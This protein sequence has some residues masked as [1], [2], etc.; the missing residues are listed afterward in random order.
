MSSPLR[1]AMCV[2]LVALLSAVSAAAE[3]EPSAAELVA[4]AGRG[5]FMQF[6]EAGLRTARLRVAEDDGGR[7]WWQGLKSRAD[8]FLTEPTEVPDCEGAS[9]HYVYF[10]TNCA[11]TLKA[12]SPRRHVCPKC[13]A[14]HS[15]VQYDR[16]YASSRHGRAQDVVETLGLAFA[17]TGQ[18]AYG[19]KAKAYLLGYAERYGSYELHNNEGWGAVDEKGRRRPHLARAHAQP[20]DE[21]VWLIALLRGFDAT[22]TLFSD[23]ERQMVSDRL[24]R[25]A[26][27]VVRDDNFGIQNHECWH[28]SAYG[29]AGLALGD[30]TLVT[31]AIDGRTG[32]KQQLARGVLP[33]G[34]W[35]EG[36]PGYHLYALN[37]LR[38]MVMA[39]A[40]LGFPVPE[41]YRKMFSVPLE[42]LTP[43]WKLPSVNNGGAPS[44]AGSGQSEIY[45]CAWTWW[46]DPVFAA[47]LAQGR[48]ATK[49]YVFLGTP[50]G[51]AGSAQLPFG[52]RDF[53]GMGL[54][55][56]RTRTPGCTNAAPDN[57]VAIDYG[58]NGNGHGHPDK[59]NLILYGHGQPIAEDFGSI[60]YGAQKQ[61]QWY[62]SS[63]AHNELVMDGRNQKRGR[64]RRLFFNGD[65]ETPRGA[66]DGG[67][68]YP[69]A[70]VCRAVALHGDCVFDLVWTESDEAHDWEWAFHARGE[71]A[72]SIPSSVPVTLPP[73]DLHG[74]C[75][76]GR[77]P[78]GSQAWSWVSDVREGALDGD[79]SATWRRPDGAAVLGVVQSVRDLD[80]DRPA[81][82]R[83]RTGVGSGIP[84]DVR[85]DLAVP[86]VSGR[87]LLFA[88][89]LLPGK[90]A[91]AAQIRSCG[92]L[93]DGS[94]RLTARVRFRDYEMT[95]SPAG[96][97][98]FVKRPS[99]DFPPPNYWC[100]WST[101]R[102]TLKESRAARKLQFQG[103]QGVSGQRANL[104]ERVLFDA[105]GWARTYWPDI[106]KDLFLLLDDGWDVPA[107]AMPDAKGLAAFGSLVPDAQRF[108]SFGAADERLGGLV[109]AI[110]DCGWRGA[111]V[112]VA[113]QAPGET[114]AN[115]PS[116][117]DA[118]VRASWAARLRASR[119]ADVRYWKVDW[120]AQAGDPAF[121]AM[122]CDVRDSVAPDLM[123]ENCLCM[124]PV[125]GLTRRADG[126]FAGTGRFEL[127]DN[128]AGWAAALAKSDVW[129]TYDYL[130]PFMHA[131]TLER[132]ATFARLAEEA[133]SP[134]LFNVEGAVL[135]GAALGHAIGIMRRYEAGAAPS[136]ESLAVAWQRI[137]PPFGHDWGLTT[138]TS[139]ETLEESW[140]F[141]EG[142]TWF[143]AAFGKRL[144]QR[145]PAV[146]ARGMK[147]PSVQV[148]G[149][150][151][152]VCAAR[153]PNGARALA[154][155]PRRAEGVEDVTTPAAVVLDARLEDRA[156]FAVFGRFDRLVLA[157]GM[158]TGS[159]ILARGILDAAAKDVTDLC[160]CAPDG[161]VVIPFAVVPPP[162]GVCTP[163]VILT[164]QLEK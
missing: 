88:S 158:P 68:A 51:A 75:G 132:C 63:L 137:A 33:D 28:L 96:V 83:L 57:Y 11:E 161:S 1:Q 12:L 89:V 147:L 73:P 159:R 138:R 120:G 72:T 114:R 61:W 9:G 42:M 155:L 44:F 113:C 119:A 23:A 106:R 94:L 98:D 104:N 48:R 126:A 25:P 4:R 66:F 116:A 90:E 45:E 112:W 38:P 121:R 30:A 84:Q 128:R 50:L 43:D 53:E 2:S 92:R 123:V 64:G 36:S 47:K 100:T 127:P 152:F 91:S 56:L 65:P 164:A 59:L 87:R 35:Y 149:K 22:R 153:F 162:Q 8:R 82:G 5:P 151:P 124:G 85:C 144:F 39:L 81:V 140:R 31:E 80:A 129:R 139:D 76:W 6:T 58:P 14:A 32:L 55:V 130:D 52:S 146:M 157:Q 41:P 110:R 46:G 143:R 7:A 69:G 49:E 148:A 29:L 93:P 154:C 103:D 99:S 26:A 117:S 105:D 67:D 133:R 145:A 24:F 60:S 10:C 19:E 54:A 109:R 136:D 70:R 79:W 34:L 40:N 37:A 163:N 3:R 141:S 18:R 16:V 78:D 122:I 156:P 142:S 27:Q 95:V 134:V 135:L 97:V 62:R 86:R 160:A 115:R 74:N 102:L 107:G 20:L 71:A 101:Q 77:E 150:P 108:A 125:N 118:A 15:G 131:T 111:A 13:G 21:A 17:L